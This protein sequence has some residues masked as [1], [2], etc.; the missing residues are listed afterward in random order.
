MSY[1]D[2]LHT[3]KNVGT[4]EKTAVPELACKDKNNA[5]FVRYVVR[6]EWCAQNVF[7][8]A[9]LTVL[10]NFGPISHMGLIFGNSERFI[11][12]GERASQTVT[13]HWER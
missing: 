10:S 2:S 1:K 5:L 8:K 4:N 9:K 3:R 11:G 13:S 6:E 7:L 12:N